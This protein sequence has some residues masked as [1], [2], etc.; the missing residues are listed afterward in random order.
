MAAQQGPQAR[1]VVGVDGSEPS[2]DALRW[3]ITQAGLTGAAVEAVIAWHVPS[4]AAAGYGWAPVEILNTP[5]YS[6][7]AQKVVTDVV[8][9][10]ADPA[11][12]VPII[13]K[14]VEGNPARVLLDAAQG[15]QLLV[16]GSR[17]LGGFTEALL[18]SVSQHCV[19]H[20]PCPV[21]IIRE[22]ASVG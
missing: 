11:G 6:E 16:V 1:I 9:N 4:L 19:H 5:E 21:V 2:R 20:A 10:I 8:S 3:A 22:H 14:A 12:T 15:A 7:S 17:G 13:T 18:G